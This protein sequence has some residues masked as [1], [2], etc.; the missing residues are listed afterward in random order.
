M[1]WNLDTILSKGLC[2]LG[3]WFCPS[4]DVLVS[5]NLISKSNPPIDT[6]LSLRFD[7]NEFWIFKLE[8]HNLDGTSL[9]N[10]LD[11]LTDPMDPTSD[12]RWAKDWF[13]GAAKMTFSF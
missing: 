4:R 5:L 8:G 7:I 1:I 3:N 6:C 13:L 10:R 11:N 2:F 9:L 12:T